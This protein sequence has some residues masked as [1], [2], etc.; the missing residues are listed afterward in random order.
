MIFINQRANSKQAI[1]VAPVVHASVVVV[2]RVGRGPVRASFTG[3]KR[4]K[5]G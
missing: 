4:K 5:A 3:K 1:T 2:D